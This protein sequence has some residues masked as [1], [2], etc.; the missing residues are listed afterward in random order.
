MTQVMEVVF[1]RGAVYRYVGVPALLFASF[2]V[3][4]SKGRFFNSNVRNQY[5]FTRV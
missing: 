5:A 1:R 3:A 2:L 4:A